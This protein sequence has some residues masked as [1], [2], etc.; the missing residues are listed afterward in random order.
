MHTYVTN[1]FR[2]WPTAVYRVLALTLHWS[3]NDSGR[4]HFSPHLLMQTT[5]HSVC[6]LTNQIP[7]FHTKCAYA[8]DYTPN[9]KPT[10]RCSYEQSITSDG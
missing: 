1:N 7:A 10:S 4:A 8:E 5:I 6:I 9:V 2:L 3:I